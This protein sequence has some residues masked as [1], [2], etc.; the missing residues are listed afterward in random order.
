MSHN[1]YSPKYFRQ[2]SEYAIEVAGST[3]R[4]VIHIVTRVEKIN[5]S[6]CSEEQEVKASSQWMPANSLLRSSTFQ[7]HP[8]R[9]R[10]EVCSGRTCAGCRGDAY[11]ILVNNVIVRIYAI[12]DKRQKFG[13]IMRLRMDSMLKMKIQSLREGWDYIHRWIY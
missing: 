1:L 12:H 6:S 9:L 3:V 7:F 11:A 10:T 8:S 4:V 2:A 13:R 5:W